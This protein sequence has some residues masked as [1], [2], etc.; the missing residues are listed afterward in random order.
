MNG[1]IF[2]NEMGQYAVPGL[3]TGHGP[4]REVIN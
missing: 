2:V 4:T 3:S 1:F